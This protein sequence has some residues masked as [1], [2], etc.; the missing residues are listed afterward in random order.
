MSSGDGDC[1]LE[2]S[3]RLSE[4]LGVNKDEALAVQ[5]LQRGSDLGH[6]GCTHALAVRYQNGAGVSVNE[7]KAAEL[8]Q[9]GVD[10]RSVLF[11]FCMNSL[12]A[13]EFNLIFQS[14]T[15]NVRVGL[16]V[17]ASRSKAAPPSGRKGF[18]W[19]QGAGTCLDCVGTR[20][21]V[22]TAS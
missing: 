1:M 11:I 9:Q 17:R 12:I 8:F 15:F 3:S 10:N 14:R 21:R 20:T 16:S 19:C 4:A 7:S 5:L 22:A 13:F 18:C 2:M 6:I